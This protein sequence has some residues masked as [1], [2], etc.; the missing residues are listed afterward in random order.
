MVNNGVNE[1]LEAWDYQGRI[2]RRGLQ[3][4]SAQ[5]DLAA[6][7]VEA[8]FGWQRQAVAD[9]FGQSAVTLALQST[10]FSFGHDYLFL[11]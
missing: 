3:A 9:Q 8:F 6:Q 2:I 7:N 4:G 11:H 10:G 5:T 1:T